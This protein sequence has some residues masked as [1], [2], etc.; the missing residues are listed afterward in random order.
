MKRNINKYL[1]FFALV[2]LGW[3]AMVVVSLRAVYLKD[4]QSTAMSMQYVRQVSF[5]DS[6][7]YTIEHLLK[8][9]RTA[10]YVGSASSK[11]N[12]LLPQ[13]TGQN[14][15]VSTMSS[16]TNHQ[17]PILNH[18]SPII[19]HQSPIAYHQSSIAYNLSPIRTQSSQQVQSRGGGAQVVAQQ[20][21]TARSART[22]TPMRAQ[23]VSVNSMPVYAVNTGIR[24][25]A[26]VPV[27]D[28]SGSAVQPMAAAPHR[29]GA[30]PPPPVT[31]PDDEHQLGYETPI[32][33]AVL[34]LLLMAL[35]LAVLRRRKRLEI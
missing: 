5:V 28:E 6:L 32:G 18:Q 10:Y 2:A 23:M 26:A 4:S 11:G 3:A 1:F 29:A 21:H 22:I 34:P 9:E 19:N 25:V 31:D 15:T 17:S 12:K 27:I 30:L 16:I 7:Q 35:C 8:G 14:A 33:D 13:S 24:S 20:T